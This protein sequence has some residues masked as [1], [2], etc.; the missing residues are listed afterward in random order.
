[1]KQH[2]VQ[3]YNNPNVSGP[4][5]SNKSV[6]LSKVVYPQDRICRLTRLVD[7]SLLDQEFGFLFKSENAPSS[8][9]IFGLLYLQSI[10]NLS[11]EEVMTQWVKTPEWQYFCGQEHLTDV[12]PLHNASLSIWSRVI[13]AQGRGAMVTAL[14]S[15]R[16]SD[17]LH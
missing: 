16:K 17:N 4:I 1:M 5:A 15:L 6:P 14:V 7:W 8:R 9:L 12:F 13:G 11:F 10:E 2:A 3:S